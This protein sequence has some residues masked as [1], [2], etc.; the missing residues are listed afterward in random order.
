[1]YAEIHLNRNVSWWPEMKPLS[2]WIARNQFVLQSGIPVSDVLVYPVKPNLVDGPFNVTPDQPFS[3]INA[4]DAANA[5]LLHCLATKIT[6]QPYACPH[7]L[8]RASIHTLQEARDLFTLV[9]NGKTLWCCSSPPGQWPVLQGNAS[10][11][12][13]GLL[14]AFQQATGKGR[15]RDVCHRNW[16]S[17]LEE[18]QS[19]RWSG[20]GK[21][22]FQHR[23]LL[24]AEV[25]LLT[26]WEE[27]FTGEVSFPHKNLSPEIWDADTGHVHCVKDYTVRDGRTVISCELSAN[28]SMIV[29]FIK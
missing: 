11:E 9:Q 19:V 26:S 13:E 20:S 2:T 21:L 10:K 4:V 25:Y 28:E 8:L 12:A 18:L 24:G 7:I 16:Q 17:V 27:P 3:A 15:V 22:S 23:R 1:M 5:H 14:A 6:E 29:A